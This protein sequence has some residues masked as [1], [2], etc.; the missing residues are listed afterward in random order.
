MKIKINKVGSNPIDSIAQDAA[1]RVKRALGSSGDVGTPMSLDAYIE[2]NV[3]ENTPQPLDFNDDIDNEIN[4]DYSGPFTGVL[5]TEY[6]QEILDIIKKYE[7]VKI[8]EVLEL[9]YQN[10][11]SIDYTV[12]QIKAIMSKTSN[13][14]KGL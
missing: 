12:S 2:E 10:R 8:G 5:D 7:S 1:E 9:Y 13:L 6:N 14:I 4:D 11:Q 3:E